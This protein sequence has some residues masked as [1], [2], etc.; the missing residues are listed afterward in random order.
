MLDIYQ[1]TKRRNIYLAL[2]TDLEGYSCFSIYQNDGIRMHFILKEKIQCKLLF[3]ARALP[4]I[5]TFASKSTN[6]LGYRELREPFRA[7]I[8]LM[9]RQM[10]KPVA[11][12]LSYV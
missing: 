11:L 4:V 9:S 8:K 3:L 12:G 10:L 5:L 6:S 1:D 7:K 2:D